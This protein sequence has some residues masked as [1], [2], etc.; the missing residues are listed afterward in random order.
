MTIFEILEKIWELPWYKV[1]VIAIFDD[2]YFLI[3]MWW[4]YVGLII[5]G[6]GIYFLWTKPKRKRSLNEFS[7]KT[8]RK[9]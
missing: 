5:L 8:K 7:Q 3:K 9:K 2:I 6:F 4:L 1:M